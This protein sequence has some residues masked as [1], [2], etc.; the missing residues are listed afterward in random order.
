[1]KE[2]TCDRLGTKKRGRRSLTE[3]CDRLIDGDKI[4]VSIFFFSLNGYECRRSTIGKQK[5]AQ[6]PIDFCGVGN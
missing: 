2:G 5:Q 4:A 6:S 3:T 1:M